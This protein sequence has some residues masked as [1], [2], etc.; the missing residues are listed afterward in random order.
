MATI[1]PRSNELVVRIVYDGAPL[2]GKSSSVRALGRGL[3]GEVITP[4]EVN[5]RTLYFDWL[6]YTGG[7]FEG[8]RIRCQIV[9]VPGQATLAPRRRHLLESADAIVFVGDSSPEGFEADRSYLAGLVQVLAGVSAPPVGVVLQA[10]KRDHANAVPVSAIREM[11]DAVGLRAAV[12]E[13]IALESNGVREAFVFA[14]RLALDRVREL[15]RTRELET[16]KP[17]VDGADDLLRALQVREN[18]AMD[19][20][21]SKLVH[22]P[23]AEVRAVAELV[24]NA[25]GCSV[26][27]IPDDRVA[28]GLIWPPIGGRTILHEVAQTP[29]SLRRTGEGDWLGEAG[30]RWRLHSAAAAV[31]REVEQGREELVQSARTLAAG[32][33]SASNDRCLALA[34]DGYGAFRLWHVQRLNAS[35]R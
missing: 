35:S 17:S 23:L 21:A 18:G 4:A 1:D 11:L 28:S 8:R 12:V 25:G 5:G 32:G 31:F 29:I 24:R 34:A 7:L 2:A 15:M 22:T 19:L 30:N 33:R 6:D 10:N 3:G 16:V 9:S 27:S 26:P 14:V 13:S 20:A